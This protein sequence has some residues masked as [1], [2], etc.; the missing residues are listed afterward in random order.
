MISF[1]HYIQIG[2]FSKQWKQDYL[3]QK[4]LADRTEDKMA[5]ELCDEF[6][7]FDFMNFSFSDSTSSVG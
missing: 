3:P 6:M 4:I 1:D 2:N 7:S 5:K